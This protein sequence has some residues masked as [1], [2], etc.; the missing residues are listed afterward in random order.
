ME[1]DGIKSS[2]EPFT[3]SRDHLEKSDNV[4]QKTIFDFLNTPRPEAGMT[5][6]S[7]DITVDFSYPYLLDVSGNTDRFGKG[8]VYVKVDGPKSYTNEFPV[9]LAGYFQSK[10]IVDRFWP[11]GDYTVTALSLIHI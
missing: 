6:S 9:N 2:P 5:I 8:F 7:N 3:I 4:R 10:I 11:S 1:Y